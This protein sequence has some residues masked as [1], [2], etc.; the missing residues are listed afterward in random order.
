MQVLA[1]TAAM[2]KS[3]V[4]IDRIALEWIMMQVYASATLVFARLSFVSKNS[5]ILAKFFAIFPEFLS[6][7]ISLHD[8]NM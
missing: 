4:K 1:A 2:Q 3:R 6:R 8:R 7:E 5:Q